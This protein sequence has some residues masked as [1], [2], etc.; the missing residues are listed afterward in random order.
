MEETPVSGLPLPQEEIATIICSATSEVF[1]TMLGIEITAGQLESGKTAGAKK[2]GVVALLGLAGDWVGSGSL[3]CDQPFACKMASALLM[4][5][6][7]AVD[8]DVLDAVAEV[9]NMVIGNVKTT[10]E[11]KLGPLGLSVPTVIY[12]R[13]FEAHSVGH[14]D[15]VIVPFD[16]GEGNLF[17]VQLSI[18][19]NKGG[20]GGRF[21]PGFPLTNSV[22]M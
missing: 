15:W 19:P 22:S 5:E 8:D 12:G 14:N 13:N 7:A 20:R 3:S 16:A 21:H 18:V 1:S 17:N 2:S 11:E 9:A 10:L 6:Y 4:A